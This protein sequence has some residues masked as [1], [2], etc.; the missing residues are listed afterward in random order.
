MTKQD[1]IL[2]AMRID[3]GKLTSQDLA[4]DTDDEV[5]KVN[6][7]LRNLELA[8]MV[9]RVGFRHFGSRKPH[10][11]WELGVTSGERLP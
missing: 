7:T 2:S 8:G 9:K 3:G 1:R 4:A 11:V 5:H 10:I 6:A